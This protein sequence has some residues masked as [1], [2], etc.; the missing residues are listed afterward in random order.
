MFH[1]LFHPTFLQ[2]YESSELI[3]FA[4]AQIFLVSCACVGTVVDKG[5]CHPR[6]YDFYMCAHAGMIVCSLYISF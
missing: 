6:N 2:S 3:S 1:I 5:I 4:F